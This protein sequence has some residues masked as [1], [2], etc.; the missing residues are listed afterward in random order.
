MKTIALSIGLAAL[1]LISSAPTADARPY[2]RSGQS[3]HIYISGYRSCGT[4]IY[5]ERYLVGYDRCGN[6]V[7]GYRQVAYNP[8]P[9]VR[10]C[11]PRIQTPYYPRGPIHNRPYDNRSGI[12]IRG[13]ICR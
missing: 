11:P 1:A 6:P 7:W 12:V 13:T 3:S 8:R 10:P 9:A 2:G 5:T 4:P